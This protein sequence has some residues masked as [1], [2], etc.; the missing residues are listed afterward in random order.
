M[1]Y[2][3]RWFG[4]LSKFRYPNFEEFCHLFDI[5]CLVESKLL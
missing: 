2:Q 3:L 1:F 5:V 4:L